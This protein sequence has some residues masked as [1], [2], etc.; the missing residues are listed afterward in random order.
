M[1]LSFFIELKKKNIKLMKQLE[2]DILLY[3]EIMCHIG[4]NCDYNYVT[5]DLI[6]Y[7]NKLSENCS[8]K[9]NEINN[10]VKGINNDIQRLCDHEFVIDTIDIDPEKSKTV[11]Y[12]SICE[13]TKE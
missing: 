1:N 7:Y 4:D 2:E 13:Y 5:V 11:C 10:I 12:C 3:H 6:N 9:I 8:E